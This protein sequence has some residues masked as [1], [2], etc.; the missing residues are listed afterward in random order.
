MRYT[1]E[2]IREL[3]KQLDRRKASELES[4]TLEL[5][6][7]SA[8][9]DSSEAGKKKFYR[10]L[11]E[12]AVCF[13]NHRGGTLVLGVKDRVQGYKRAITGCGV[14]N[15]NEIRMRIY[16]MTDPK[17]LVEVEELPIDELGI[18]LL[19]IHFPSGIG[20]HTTTD[21]V[22]KVR[23]GTD[24]K[25]MTGSMRQ[26][27]L[28][29][30]G[31]LDIT[32]QPLDTPPQELVDPNEMARL[33]RLI[34]ARKPHTT[35][36]KLRDSE[37]MEQVGITQ[38]GRL[39]LAGLL[40]VGTERAI[41]QYVPFHSIEYLRMKSDI[42]YERREIY[43]CGLLNALESV[44]RNISLY[45]TITTVKAGLYHYEIKDFP[46]ES[47]REALL[48]AVQHRDYTQPSA[49]FVKH[50]ANRL[51]ISNPGGFPWGISTEN[52]LRQDS[53]PRNRHL[54]EILRRI[55]L[56]EKAGVGVKRIFYI[57]LISGKRPPEYW[58]DGA[59]VRITLFN[60]AIDEAFVR[61]LR[62]REREGHAVSL[63][64]LI[65]LAAL[66][67]Q[68]ELSLPDAAR[69]L[70]L[71]YERTRECLMQMVRNGLL[72][73]S[74]IRKGQVFRLSSSVYRELGESVA[75]IRERG[76]DALRHEE[77][78]LSYVRQFGSISNRQVRELLGVD[79]FTASKTLRRLV[80]AGKLKR[81]GSGDKNA[82]YVLETSD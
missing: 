17:I 26:Q 77:L 61:L 33:R 54:T 55:G 25:P 40:L 71:N 70:Q 35:L 6:E 65:V 11:A 52:I 49:V 15:L 47:Y 74:G 13:A 34:E 9:W 72:E 43:T 24:C 53:R 48:N 57:Q 38:E 14:Y 30:T 27:R 66:V 42:E 81:I 75:Y 12:Y 51:E 29:E 46:E 68:R 10:I 20:V 78:I 80:D 69:L 60:G 63:D 73:R 18:R 45:N 82:A 56:V 79:K 28:I 1:A 7:W 2:Q 32:A 76:I 19:L 58:T 8:E 23:I 50:H 64:E 67:R 16:E 5:K 41:R 39:T 62:K 31:Q 3:L 44:G 21:G 37:L 4:E 22:A 59:S 36:L